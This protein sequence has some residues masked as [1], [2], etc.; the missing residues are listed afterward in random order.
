MQPV[1]PIVPK[2]SDM[3]P[4]QRSL[5][6]SRVCPCCGAAIVPDQLPLP[7]LKARLLALV[8]SNPGISGH[9]LRSLLYAHDA[10]GGPEDR[11]VLHVHVHQLNQRLDRYGIALR[12][13]GGYRIT[14]R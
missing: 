1:D 11:K 2:T 6:L 13:R 10:S 3:K 8:R 14:S 9:E 7:P 5:P 12:G 4:R